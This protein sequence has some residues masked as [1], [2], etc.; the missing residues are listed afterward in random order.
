MSNGSVLRVHNDKQTGPICITPTADT[1]GNKQLHV[2]MTGYKLFAGA[3][4]HRY[5]VKLHIQDKLQ[6]FNRMKTPER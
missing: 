2:I 3:F 5:N 1:G 6:D 4:M